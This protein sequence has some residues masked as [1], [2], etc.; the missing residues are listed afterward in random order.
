MNRPLAPAKTLKL[1]TKA[2]ARAQSRASSRAE[3]PSVCAGLL[4]A[5]SRGV[6]RRLRAARGYDTTTAYFKIDE[7]RRNSPV[8]S[9]PRFVAGATARKGEEFGRRITRPIDPARFPIC[10]RYGRTDELPPAQAHWTMLRSIS[11]NMPSVPGHL[12][13]ELRVAEH[14]VMSDVYCLTEAAFAEWFR[15][16]RRTLQCWRETGQ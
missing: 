16:S 6:W 12:A 5:P 1:R 10:H 14:G 11:S 7:T 8:A 4:F 3:C 2:F 13:G 9:T 15:M